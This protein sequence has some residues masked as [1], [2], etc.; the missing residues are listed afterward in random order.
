[1]K[2]PFTS[3]GGVYQARIAQR[4]DLRRDKGT[5]LTGIYC[6]TIPYD[7]GDTSM[8]AKLCV[9]IGKTG[10]V[11]LLYLGLCMQYFHSLSWE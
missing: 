8:R 1:M 5:P 2:L 7:V 11:L 3:P 4:V 9:R 10:F 6:C